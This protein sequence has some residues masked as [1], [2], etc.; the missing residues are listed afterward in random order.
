[1][2]RLFYWQDFFIGKTFLLARLFYWQDFFIGKTWAAPFLF[3][4]GRKNLPNKLDDPSNQRRVGCEQQAKLRGLFPDRPTGEVSAHK[5][6]GSS[7]GL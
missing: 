2:A 5:S 7:V 3:S 4:V 1:L 6:N